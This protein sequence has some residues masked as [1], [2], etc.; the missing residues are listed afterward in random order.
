MPETPAARISASLFARRAVSSLAVAASTMAS[1]FLPP[2]RTAWIGRR[3]RGRTRH[4][5]PFVLGPSVVRLAERDSDEE[6]CEACC[7][8]YGTC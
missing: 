4:R 5:V 2:L 6:N 3:G 7:H 1:A 8:D